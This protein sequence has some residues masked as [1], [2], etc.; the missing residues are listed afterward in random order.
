MELVKNIE[1][2]LS[3]REAQESFWKFCQLMAPDFYLDN[4][5]HLKTLCNTLQALYEGRI[6]RNGKNPWKIIK[7]KTIGYKICK[8]LRIHMPPQ[9]GKTRTLILFCGWVYGQNHSERIVAGSYNDKSAG[10][11]SRFTRDLIA[12]ERVTE[13]LI[14]ND[15]FPN[16]KISQGNAGFEKWALE[17]EF[18]SYLGAGIGGTLTGKGG[19]VRI[20]DDPVKDAETAFNENS[21]ETIWTWYTGTFLSRRAIK[22]PIDIICMTPWAKGDICGRIDDSK[23]AGDWYVLKLP[24]MN[25]KGE[26]LCPDLLDKEQ[27]E[28]LEDTMNPMIFKANY[29]LTPVDMQGCLYQNLKTYNDLPRDERGNIAIEKV[30]AYVDT[31]DE[32]SDSLGA[33]VFGVYRGEIFILDVLFS[34]E[35]M[36]KTEPQTANLLVR[37][38]VTF[39]KI[40][41]NNGGKGFARNV[42][43]IIWDKFKTRSVN[44]EW[45]HQSANKMAR[46][47]S[48]SS[49][50]INHVYFPNGWEKRWPEFYKEFISFNKEGKNK[51]DDAADFITGCGEMVDGGSYQGLFDYMKSKA[52]IQEKKEEKVITECPHYNTITISNNKMMRKECKQCGKVLKEEFY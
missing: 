6:V 19:T 8:K 25:E 2:I 42:Q 50:V 15:I 18:F 46:I 21:L 11:F 14:Y 45:F 39:A 31:A 5:W 38:N 41:S 35:P 51:H 10:D 27:Y 32:G 36:E 44:I 12:E 52:Q 29:Q 47:L 13:E 49:Y 23:R 40:E 1:T 17:G 4:R 22:E 37:N 34:S 20:I 24:A 26:T 48:K 28:E 16:V 43:N 9:H 7:D 3:I 33:G 30:W